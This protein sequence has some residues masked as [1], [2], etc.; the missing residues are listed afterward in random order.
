MEKEKLKQICESK[1]IPCFLNHANTIHIKV[2][3][4]EEMKQFLEKENVIYRF[5]KLP[6]DG[7]EWLTIV[8]YPNF[9]ESNILKKII[10][11]KIS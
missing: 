8:L 7:Y 10:D 5:R 6:H 1:K 4:N 3:N 2:D 9:C 11:L